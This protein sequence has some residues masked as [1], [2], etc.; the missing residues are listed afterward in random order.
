MDELLFRSVAE[1]AAAV[2]NRQVSATQVVAAC[3]DAI[4]DRSALNS[5]TFVDTE[6]ALDRAR[7]LDGYPGGG[8]ELAG[9]PIA[10]KDVIDHAGRT[11][12]CGS[13]FYRRRALQS[14]AIVSRLEAAGAIVIGRTLPHE[15]GM[16]VTT[17]NPWWGAARNP[18]NPNTSPG[19]SSGGS[20]AAVAAGLAFGAI[21]TDTGGSVR[22]PAA[23]CGVMG[24]KVTQG[25]IPLDGVFPLA[26]PIDTVGPLARS[27]DDLALLYRAMSATLDR[28]PSPRDHAPDSEPLRGYSVGVP[29]EWIRSEP[30]SRS[31]REAFERAIDQISDAGARVRL[32]RNPRISSDW[33][34]MRTIV[35]FHARR[36]HQ[37]WFPDLC[38]Q[39]GQD[40]A[41]LLH[42]AATITPADYRSARAWTRQV[43][44]QVADAMAA[45]DL[46]ITPATPCQ[47]KDLGSNTIDIDGRPVDYRKI[48][49]AFLPLVNHAD[50]PAL[51]AP[52]SG[53]GTPSP[54]I[55]FIGKRN[56]EEDLLEFGR[57]CESLGLI[58]SCVA[59]VES[60]PGI[61]GAKR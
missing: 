19:G 15:F 26:P 57:T 27:V 3:L 56:A 7:S 23:L 53:G 34:Q 44:D 38:R 42:E 22:L 6:A 39:Y 16:G 45:V 40:V 43:G 2:R 61:A 11:T 52:L 59:P 1:I 46:L 13:S 51:V 35:L 37:R 9:V 14:A 41:A 33:E 50:L 25:R 4:A 28:V 20:A 36:I 8:G 54:A 10:L 17:E 32:I 55:Q 31:I 58:S 29:E 5:F 60:V 30:L 24:L 49:T 21:G 48:S 47:R 12:T 18:W